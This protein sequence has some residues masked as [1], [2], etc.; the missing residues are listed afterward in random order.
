[1]FS[2]CS[3][4]LARLALIFVAKNSETIYKFSRTILVFNSNIFVYRKKFVFFYNNNKSHTFTRKLNNVEVTAITKQLVS[5]YN[6]AIF[7]SGLNINFLPLSLFLS[8][9]LSLHRINEIKSGSSRLHSTLHSPL[10]TQ[11]CRPTYQHF[12]QRK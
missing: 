8:L 2:V 12:L 11:L 9:S 4:F 1:M 6:Q 7:L 5:V 3:L 10:H